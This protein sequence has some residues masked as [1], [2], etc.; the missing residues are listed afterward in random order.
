MRLHAAV[1]PDLQLG[2]PADHTSQQPIGFI[3]RRLAFADVYFVVNTGNQPVETTVSFATFHPSGE[4]WGV[5]G[6]GSSAAVMAKNEPLRLAPYESRVFVFADGTGAKARKHGTAPQ[7]LMDL[8]SQWTVR[9]S[10]SGITR[11]EAML[12]DWTADPATLHYSGEAVYT[13]ELTLQARPSKRVY[14]EV[15]GGRP[16]AGGPSSEPAHS[17]LANGLPDPKVTRTG[18]GMR[19]YFEPPIREAALVLV[20]GQPAGA[21]WHPPYRLE[22]AKLLQAGTNRIEIHVFNTALNAWSALPPHDY[23]PLIAKY[24]DRFQMQDLDQVKPVSSG[25]LGSVRLVSEGQR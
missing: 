25:L 13:R 17:L 11:Q 16:V 6:I 4:E 1:T 9:F 12:T 14:L 3:R 7:L 18:P 15:D 8:S 20:N 10:G 5:D 23:Q 21:L 24:G 2:G 19:A 22:V